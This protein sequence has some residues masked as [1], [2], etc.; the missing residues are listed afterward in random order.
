MFAL[1]F[2]ISM[3]RIINKG[4]IHIEFTQI[5][6]LVDRGITRSVS[7]GRWKDEG[8]DAGPKPLYS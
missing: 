3:L 5:Y 1:I 8:F 2:T 4:L 6:I 7:A